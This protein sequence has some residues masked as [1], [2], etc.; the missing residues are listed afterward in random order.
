MPPAAASSP[1][2]ERAAARQAQIEAARQARALSQR[3]LRDAE[4]VMRAT[5]AAAAPIGRIAASQPGEGHQAPAPAP[6]ARPRARRPASAHSK[7]HSVTGTA[8]Q[9]PQHPPSSRPRTVPA[10]RAG[11]QPQ[12]HS[13]PAA[14]RSKQQ[15]VCVKSAAEPDIAGSSSLSSPDSVDAALVIA[16]ERAKT[17]QSTR[18]RSRAAKHW[19]ESECEARTHKDRASA[20]LAQ[21][22]RDAAK[23]EATTG[24]KQRR[25]RGAA[26]TPRPST[27]PQPKTVGSATVAATA[28]TAGVPAP[29]L[30]GTLRQAPKPRHAVTTSRIQR[31]PISVSNSCS[32]EAMLHNAL[33][34]AGPSR[35]PVRSVPI[36]RDARVAA[37]DT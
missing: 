31:S 11:P 17:Q 15:R 9:A 37:T 13:R 19:L 21:R 24:R 30:N 33:R 29:V 3:A 10:R 12:G 22:R 23:R 1:G 14:T 20:E 8:P 6:A 2:R 25:R 18:Q 4:A 26:S 27:V 36:V 32:D 5:A 35:R 16:L 28:A 7:R 34:R